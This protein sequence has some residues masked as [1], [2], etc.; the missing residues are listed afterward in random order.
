MMLAVG[1]L[2]KSNGSTTTLQQNLHGATWSV[3]ATIT[4][5]ILLL[6]GKS[7]DSTNLGN[8]FN[9]NGFPVA[10]VNWLEDH[11]QSGN[12]Y[13]EFTWG[14][15]IIYRLWPE[16][17]VFIDGQTDFYGTD[18]VQEYLT[19]LNARE[20]WEN[21][22]DKYKVEWVLVPRHSV[23]AERLEMNQAWFTI[24]DDDVAIIMRNTSP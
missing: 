24:Y 21:I 13:N 4:V 20:N 14:G 17:K 19:V 10:A 12:L 18:L 22:L 8:T 6:S 11:P 3:I 5:V 15:Y 9:P 7:L 16:T 1:I 2:R 23:I